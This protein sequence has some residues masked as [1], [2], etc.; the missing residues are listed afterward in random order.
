MVQTLRSQMRQSVARFD[1]NHKLLRNGRNRFLC[2]SVAEFLHRSARHKLHHYAQRLAAKRKDAND[3]WV[4]W[5]FGDE[6]DLSV[7]LFVRGVVGCRVFDVSAEYF[8]VSRPLGF[9]IGIGMSLE[10]ELELEGLWNAF[11]ISGILGMSLESHQASRQR[12]GNHEQ[13]IGHTHVHIRQLM[14]LQT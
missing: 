7:Q 9:G 6:N 1:Q 3:V 2:E 4:R 10:L 11:G 13:S 8:E 14:R 5:Y 12:A